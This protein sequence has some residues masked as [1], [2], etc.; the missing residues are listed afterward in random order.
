MVPPCNSS[1]LLRFEANMMKYQADLCKQ[2]SKV[3]DC[4][5]RLLEE[6]EQ[7]RK[8]SASQ[9]LPRKDP[10][11][12]LPKTKDWNNYLKDNKELDESPRIKDYN[13]EMSSTQK[14][15]Q[16]NPKNLSVNSLLDLQ[17]S[18]ESI[19]IKKEN[20]DDEQTSK[21]SDDLLPHGLKEKQE[22]ET[23]GQVDGDQ[24]QQLY[25]RQDI[26]HLFAELMQQANP[27]QGFESTMFQSKVFLEA[28]DLL[29]KSPL[30]TLLK[31][32]SIEVKKNYGPVPG[33]SH[34]NAMDSSD[35]SKTF[36]NS[37]QSGKET[38]DLIIKVSFLRC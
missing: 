21:V 33:F 10:H 13:N 9:F 37:S 8:G 16:I 20:T 22:E 36:Q 5:A 30:R 23:V 4:Q 26:K 27:N 28:D 18:R 31:T 7:V 32:M 3:L 14:S 2:R 24:D 15:P 17:D 6:Q 35:I 11:H 1:L 12:T 29:I 25:L 19:I 38:H 34:E